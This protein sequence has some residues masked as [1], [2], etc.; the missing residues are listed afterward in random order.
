M[1]QRRAV[2]LPPRPVDCTLAR[3]DDRD[4]WT[5]VREAVELFGVDLG[6]LLRVETA[7][8]VADTAGAARSGIDPAAE[9]HECLRRAK[10]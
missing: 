7:D 6:Y 4:E 2:E 10:R 8:Q 3:A 9:G 1:L 5:R